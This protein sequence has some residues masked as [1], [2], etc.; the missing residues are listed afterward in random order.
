MQHTTKPGKQAASRSVRWAQWRSQQ[1]FQGVG[2]PKEGE[3]LAMA[4]TAMARRAVASLPPGATCLESPSAT[5]QS[6]VPSSRG[7]V[8]FV[9]DLLVH[10]NWVLDWSGK[11]IAC[12]AGDTI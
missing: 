10:N 8:Q 3:S 2:R 6:P 11:H 7:L 12:W 5:L 4:V 1:K 9:I